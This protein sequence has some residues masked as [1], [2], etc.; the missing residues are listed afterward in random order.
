MSLCVYTPVRIWNYICQ[1]LLRFQSRT[2]AR[3]CRY[4]RMCVV[5]GDLQTNPNSQV[6]S[7]F[8][9]YVCFLYL[10]IYVT[11]IAS[12]FLSRMSAPAIVVSWRH[13]INIWPA[14]YEMAVHYRVLIS[15][16]GSKRWNSRS[17]GVYVN[18][19]IVCLVSQSRW[20][21]SSSWHTFVSLA[22]RVK[23]SAI[24]HICVKLCS[25]CVC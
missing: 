19:R 15:S 1:R 21:F 24:T 11:G 4:H 20:K 25:F 8:S 10:Y 16:C 23:P 2:A 22:F 13:Q 6:T 17:L 18:S 5:F 3:V 9:K 12:S 7:A 14:N